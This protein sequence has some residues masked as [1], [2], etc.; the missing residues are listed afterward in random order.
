[1]TPGGTLVVFVTAASSDEAATI[2]RALVEEHLAACVNV[3]P[4]IRSFFWWEGRLQEANETLLVM[5]T[6]RERYGALEARVRSLH[7]YSVPE[8]LAL[9]VESGSPDYV[10]WVRESVHAEG[11]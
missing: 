11:R 8:I 2:A 9:P 3:V 5:K 4:G 7:S 1:M 10:A 6:H